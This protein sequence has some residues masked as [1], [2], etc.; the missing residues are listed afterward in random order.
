MKKNKIIRWISLFL[1]T[2]F[3]L[4]CNIRRNNDLAN[5]PQ[6]NAAFTDTTSVQVI[7]SVYDF[8]KAAEGNKVT[9]NFRFKNTGTKPLIISAAHAS[10]GCTVPEKPE[11][12]IQPG[13]TGVLKVVFN[14][15]DRPG[16]A[17][18]TITVVSNAYPEFPVLLLKGEVE[19]QH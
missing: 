1:V 13:K 19:A 7:D 16:P 15:T 18:K 12:P 5:L 4:S 17:H 2:G 6:S 8:G 11:E 10:C 3:I 9:Y 14:T